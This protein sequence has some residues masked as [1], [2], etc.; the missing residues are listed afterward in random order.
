M[1]IESI[2]WSLVVV[3]CPKDKSHNE[4]IERATLTFNPQV[5]SL[6][7]RENPPFGRSKS[8][9]YAKA[10]CISLT[11]WSVQFTACGWIAK[12]ESDEVEMF[13]LTVT[14]TF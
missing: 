10:K 6:E 3:E 5:N 13:P 1:K 14:A 12:M 2:V 9:L 4:K 11:P 7:V 8:I